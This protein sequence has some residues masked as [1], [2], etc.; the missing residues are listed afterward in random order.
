MP[1]RRWA[2]RRILAWGRRV[3]RPWENPEQVR[4][5][6]EHHTICRTFPPA[7][8]FRRHRNDGLRAFLRA[9]QIRKPL[10]QIMRVARA[11]GGLGVILHREH[12]LAVELDAAVGAVEQGDMGLRRTLRERRLVHPKAVV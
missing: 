11:G 5:D 10:E 12:R 4:Y 8:L 7:A 1:G 2:S 3:S 9:H 6:Y